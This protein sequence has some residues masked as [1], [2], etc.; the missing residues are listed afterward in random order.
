MKRLFSLLTLLGLSALVVGCK[1]NERVELD[2][3]PKFIAGGGQFSEEPK[4]LRPDPAL[5]FF[6]DES[7]PVEMT[8]HTDRHRYPKPAERRQRQSAEPEIV[9]ESGQQ[10][11]INRLFN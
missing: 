1:T 10:A 8:V 7:G 3:I 6:D 11:R 9:Y 4:P 5:L 2:G